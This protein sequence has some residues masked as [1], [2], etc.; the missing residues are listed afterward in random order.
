MSF[1]APTVSSY[2]PQVYAS[3]T[4]YGLASEVSRD[5]SQSQVV[6]QNSTAYSGAQSNNSLQEHA[7]LSQQGASDN[8]KQIEV[9]P[10]TP[11][12]VPSP[13]IASRP[14]ASIG[15][16]SGGHNSLG[17]GTIDQ[18]QGTVQNTLAR[19]QGMDGQPSHA[20]NDLTQFE[21][22]SE[23]LLAELGQEMWLPEAVELPV[24]SQEFLPL[25]SIPPEVLPRPESTTSGP[26]LASPQ[27][28]VAEREVIPVTV[29]AYNSTPAG[30]FRQRAIPSVRE[31]QN[32]LASSASLSLGRS[33]NATLPSLNLPNPVPGRAVNPALA[34]DTVQATDPSVPLSAIPVPTPVHLLGLTPTTN[35]LTGLP[36][37]IGIPAAP[38]SL[39]VI[40]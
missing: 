7:T 5:A 9:S 2:T 18:N 16:V 33:R 11:P 40:A 14:V 23:D 27:M 22:V 37:P 35:F 17:R 31:E 10:P 32:R 25:G 15:S 26:P 24:E 30:D 28:P 4:V 36:M 39:S 6:L 38:P 3:A 21:S 34:T 20:S 12:S 19:L 13:T 29:P 8:Q 1:S